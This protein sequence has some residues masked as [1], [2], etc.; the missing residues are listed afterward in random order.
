VD[1]RIV[2]VR[3][4]DVADTDQEFAREL[5]RRNRYLTLAT[6]DGGKPW[7]APLEYVA[8]DALNLYFCSPTDTV[9]A[10]QLEQNGDVAVA[11][12]DGVQPEYEPSPAIRIAGLQ[13]TANARRLKPPFPEV[14]E[15]KI[16]MWQ[17]PMP[18]Y[19]VYQIVPRQWFIPVITDGVN[20][21]LEIQME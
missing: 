15:E 14:I 2:E 12:F 6:T 13:I 8:D 5:I 11:I 18:P 7:I 10:R 21:R 1:P 4:L 17:V 16:Q 9:H 3:S 19:A 20:D